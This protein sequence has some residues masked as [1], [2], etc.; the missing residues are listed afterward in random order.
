MYPSP[1]P[2]TDGH[3]RGLGGDHAHVDRGDHGAP[4][5]LRAREKER[6]RRT[7]TAVGS[8]PPRLA[9]DPTGGA[10][11]SSTRA[12]RSSPLLP[13]AALRDGRDLAE[14]DGRDPA[15]GILSLPQ[16]STLAPWGSAWS[17][18]QIGVAATGLQPFFLNS[19]MMVVPAVA[20]STVH[21]RPE[22]L[23]ADQ[24]A[25]P[26]RRPACSGCCCSA[27]SSRS[28]SC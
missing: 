14:A 9:G 3:R 6:W 21:R 16:A 18:A 25:V 15:G 13:S 5:L 2:A 27:A 17:T 10:R 28:R 1:S 7:P 23:R 20:V 8:M 26:R 24:V 12:H 22:R 4:H 19:L 11:R